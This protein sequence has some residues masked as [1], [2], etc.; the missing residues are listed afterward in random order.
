MLRLILFIT[1]TKWKQSLCHSTV[2]H[3]YAGVK[4]NN[5]KGP[6]TDILN[7]RDDAK[8][9]PFK[10]KEPDAKD[11]VLY[12]LYDLL[13]KMKLK[14]EKNQMSERHGLQV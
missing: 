12:V 4:L 5:K 6:T 13:E 9:H 10:W 1:A 3:S 14:G 11:Y 8:M 2:C 7:E